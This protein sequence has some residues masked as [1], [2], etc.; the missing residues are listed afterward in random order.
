M[1]VWPLVKGM[2]CAWLSPTT[3]EKIS[4][5]MGWSISSVVYLHSWASRPEKGYLCGSNLAPKINYM[6]P[7]LPRPSP[8]RLYVLMLCPHWFLGCAVSG[9]RAAQYKSDLVANGGCQISTH[10]LLL[11]TTDVITWG[12]KNTIQKCRQTLKLCTKERPKNT[13]CT[14][15]TNLGEMTHPS[16]FILFWVLTSALQALQ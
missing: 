3:I 4:V 15:V 7:I 11:L 2:Q 10:I 16:A 5:G 12:F 8:L 1:S 6:T 9:S 14:H 13:A